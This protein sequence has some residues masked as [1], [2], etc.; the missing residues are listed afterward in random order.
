MLLLSGHEC[1]AHHWILQA[2]AWH[3]SQS[4]V[5][6]PWA[7][8]EDRLPAQPGLPTGGNWSTESIFV[9]WEGLWF[10]HWCLNG[11]GLV[12]PKMLFFFVWPPFSPF[13]DK[14]EIMSFIWQVLLVLFLSVPVSSA[15]LEFS[16]ATCSRCTRDYRENQKLPALSLSPKVLRQPMFSILPFRDFLCCQL[17]FV[18]GFLVVRE[19]SWEKWGYPFLD[20]PEVPQT[21]SNRNLN[22]RGFIL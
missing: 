8:N 20:E 7:W 16:A 12:L 22:I 14:G 21:T 18:Q 4:I 1:L 13:F 15:G 3:W 11:I 9:G 6:F 10:F 17:Y 5:C 2:L 19:R